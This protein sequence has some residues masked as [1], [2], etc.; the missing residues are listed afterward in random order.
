MPNLPSAGQAKRKIRQSGAGHAF[1]LLG[2][3]SGDF[4]E[5]PLGRQV[6]PGNGIAVAGSGSAYV[7]G[8][9]THRLACPNPIRLMR[10]SRPGTVATLIPFIA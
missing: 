1:T 8:K 5:K 2:T 4:A 10:F 6:L 3:R 7:V 9:T